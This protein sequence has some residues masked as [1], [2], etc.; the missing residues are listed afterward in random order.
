VAFASIW[1]LDLSKNCG[2]SLGLSPSSPWPI[3]NLLVHPQ[4]HNLQHRLPLAPHPHWERHC[5]L[6]SSPPNVTPKKWL[7][8]VKTP[9]AIWVFYKFTE[10]N[11]S[12][13]LPTSL[14]PMSP[15]SLMSPKD[16]LSS[17]PQ[18]RQASVA[19]ARLGQ[20]RGSDSLRWN[21]LHFLEI[22]WGYME[23]KWWHSMAYGCIMGYTTNLIWY[24]YN[25]YIHVYIY[26]CIYICVCVFES[27]VSP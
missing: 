19:R 3:W 20:L 17:R 9:M 2:S 25:I 7:L 11:L 23:I 10:S 4:R 24:I 8:V 14:S 18:L 16:Q 26:T 12:F 22:W 27:V 1:T 15:M 6:G 13:Q 21:I 5:G